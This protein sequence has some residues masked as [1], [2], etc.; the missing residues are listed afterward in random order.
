[1]WQKGEIK[2]YYVELTDIAREYIE[3]IIEIPA[4]EFTTSEL[5]VA[6]RKASTVKKLKLT[7]ESIA[8]L[9]KYFGKPI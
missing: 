8:N 3:E 6:L 5:I 7:K 2:L 1:L 9:E 4:K